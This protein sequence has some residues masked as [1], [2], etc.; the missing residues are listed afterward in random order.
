ML[1]TTKSALRAH[2]ACKDRYDLLCTWAPA[3]ETAPI[4]LEDILEHNGPNDALW[5]LRTVDDDG[6]LARWFAR[7]CT[8][9]GDESIRV[10]ARN[11]ARN[12]A[13]VWATAAALDAATAVDPARSVTKAAAATDAVRAMQA[14]CLRSAIARIRAGEPLGE[15]EC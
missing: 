9:Q 13:T 7:W 3:D 15:I 8:A 1:I 10:A 5:A 2:Q 6:G 11:A 4:P 12:A 14:R